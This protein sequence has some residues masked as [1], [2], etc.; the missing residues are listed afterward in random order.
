MTYGV[1]LPVLKLKRQKCQTKNAMGAREAC[2]EAGSERASASTTLDRGRS[3]FCYEWHRDGT[4]TPLPSGEA[5]FEELTQAADAYSAKRVAEGGKKLRDDAPIGATFVL[6]PEA[7]AAL[8]MDSDAWEKWTRDAVDEWSKFWGREPAHILV[9]WDEGGPNIHLFDSMTDV[10]GDYRLSKVITPAKLRDYHRQWV[11]GMR[12]RGHDVQVHEGVRPDGSPTVGAG[13]SQADYARIAEV[14]QKQKEQG[15]ELERGRVAITAAAEKLKTDA[16]ELKRREAGL[17]QQQQTLLQQQQEFRQRQKRVEEREREVTGREEAAADLEERVN[18]SVDEF[19][20]QVEEENDKHD[21]RDKQLDA[22]ERDLDRRESE[23]RGRVRDADAYVNSV[24][25]ARK[26]AGDT[27][28][29]L[30]PIRVMK[31]FCEEMAD[32]FDRTTLTGAQ[33]L[34]GNLRIFAQNFD[35]IQENA[36]EM[37]N[38]T[39]HGIIVDEKSRADRIFSR[40]PDEKDLKLD[41]SSQ[42]RSRQYDGPSY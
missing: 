29:M 28:L 4:R 37:A 30:F 10:N 12:E 18:Y 19:R 36:P 2:L 40:L 35:E 8:L 41:Y 13:M 34:A 22:R 14:T 6:K 15:E 26:M 23:L 32:Y 24:D 16:D 42:T 1:G 7:D 11:A 33:R 3:G 21:A 20:R 9:H 39:W 27:L 38:A 17:Q 31:R 25:A 5:M